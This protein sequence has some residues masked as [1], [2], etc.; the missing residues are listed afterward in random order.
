MPESWSTLYQ[1]ITWVRR[2]PGA[3]RRQHRLLE[4]ERGAAVASHA[5]QH[6]D[7]RRD[8]DRERT[9]RPRE[10][11]AADGAERRQRDQEAAAAEAV[12]GEGRDQRGD[13]R[14]GET[15]GDHETDVGGVE[16]EPRQVERR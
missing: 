14:A 6:A 15:G 7:E 2:S 16:P 11:D 12:A 10:R 5:V 3:R 9:R 4:R 8:P 13:R 1:A